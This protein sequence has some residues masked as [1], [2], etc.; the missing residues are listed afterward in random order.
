[1]P[2]VDLD[3]LRCFVAACESRTFRDAARRRGLSPGAFSDRVARLEEV[4]GAT[5]FA[6]T[7]RVVT[8][9]DAGRRLYEHARDVL[10]AADRCGDVARDD[11]RP[12]PFELRIGT[13]FELGLS[14]VVPSLDALRAHRPERTLHLAMGDAADLLT[15]LDRNDLDAVITSSRL[16]APK[17]DYA[18]LHAETY[19][20]VGPPSHVPV[21][22]P[23]DAVGETLLDIAED[24]PLFRY[25]LDADAAAEPWPFARHE[26]L[27]GIGAVRL[28]ALAGAGVAVLPEYFV[29]ADLEAGRLV[30]LDPGR[31]LA[32]DAFRL[33]WRRG[34]PRARD[35]R[36]LASEWRDVPLV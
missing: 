35:L 7:T 4:V 20:F 26:H 13:R 24:L 2:D 15:R 9:T 21:R 36:D 8:A 33:V 16:V 31:A 27:G 14:W 10:A 29:R 11:Q 6:R 5:L 3:D 32:S 28:R 1:V 12:P 22:G 25:R 30:D 18:T 17:L 19:R 34:H 23:A